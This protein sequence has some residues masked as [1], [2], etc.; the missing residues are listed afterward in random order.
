MVL[1]GEHWAC[2]QLCGTLNQECP[3]AA[4]GP[5][6]LVLISGGNHRWRGELR[7]TAKQV[8]CE[9]QPSDS[10]GSGNASK[11]VPNPY[12]ATLGLRAPDPA[13]TLVASTPQS[14]F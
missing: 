3:P 5:S 8:V 12:C 7:V 6:I 10:H 13:Q 4:R 9:V 14:R 2:L 1:R 11:P